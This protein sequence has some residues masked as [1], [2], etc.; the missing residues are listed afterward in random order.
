MAGVEI[1]TGHAG[2]S[3]IRHGIMDSSLENQQTRP[4]S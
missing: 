3:G 2:T 4:D 1:H